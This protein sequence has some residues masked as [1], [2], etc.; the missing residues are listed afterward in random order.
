MAWSFVIIFRLPFSWMMTFSRSA[1]V[2][3]VAG[4]MLP[5]GLPFG[6]PDFPFLN[7]ELRAD[8][9]KVI[10]LTSSTI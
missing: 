3:T 1:L 9:P 8:L 5:F 6:F 10:G 4:L 7:R 2:R